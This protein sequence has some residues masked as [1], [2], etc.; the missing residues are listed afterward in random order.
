MILASVCMRGGSKGIPNKNL[1]QLLEKPLMTYTFDCAKQSKLINDIAVSS[2]SDEILEISKKNDIKHIFS[3]EK[4]LSSDSAS[5]W[6]VFRDLVIRYEKKSGKKIEY[7]VD[8][9]VTTPRRKSQHI[10][11]SITMMLKNNVDVIITGYEPER[12]PY[13]N[14]MEIGPNNLARIVKSINDSSIVCRQDAPIVY[15]LSPAVF[16]I[17]RDALFDYEHWS[18]AICMIN[19]IPRELAIDIDTELDFKLI[20][21]LMRGELENKEA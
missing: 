7:L 4:I 12:N 11:S 6:D 1:K 2:D 9:D 16:V 17:R 21:C 3:R 10:D 18:K 13:F 14:M 5:K 19:P 20:E 8:L 15:S